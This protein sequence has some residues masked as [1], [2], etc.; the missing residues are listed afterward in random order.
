VSAVQLLLDVALFPVPAQESP[1][2]K[3]RNGM[4]HEDDAPSDER[5]D[6]PDDAVVLLERGK[7]QNGQ[8]NVGHQKHG[9]MGVEPLDLLDP[10]PRLLVLLELRHDNA[11]CEHPGV[12]LLG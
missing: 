9:H 8:G 1:D 6:E 5:P 4:H 11:S 7:I 3:D 10:I 12:M 2:T